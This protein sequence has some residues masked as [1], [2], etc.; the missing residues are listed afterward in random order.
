MNRRLNIA[1]LVI[2]LSFNTP[3]VAAESEIIEQLDQALK[4][5]AKFEYGKDSG[6]LVRVEQIVV[7]SAMDTK[8]RDAVERRLIRTLA[9]A[10]TRDAKSFLCRQ[11]RTI[12]TARCVPEL[13]KLLTDPELSHMARYALGRIDAPEAGVALHR[14]LKKTSG[15][16]KAGIIN[17]LVEVNYGRALGDFMGLIGNSDKDV[18]IAAIRATGHFPCNSSVS[19][20]RR[21]RRSA[22][23]D[24]QIEISAALL[25]SAEVFLANGD[26]KRS[27]AIY[28][29]FYSGNYP[30]HLRV[31]GL[32]GLAISQGAQAAPLLIEA[33][34]GDDS[35]LRRSS[36]EFMTMVKGKEAT[37]AFVALLPSLQPDAQVLV[38]GALGDRGDAAAAQAIS[39]ATRSEH[40]AVRVAA[41]EA[42]GSVGNASAVPLLARTAATAGDR[43]KKV[44]LAGLVLLSGDD[45][46][47]VLIRS[48]NSG[49]SKVRTEIIRAIAARGVTQATGEL[50]K[51]ATD[52]NETVRREAIRALGAL[53]DVSELGV[54][55]ALAVNPKDAKD[56]AA[57]EQTIG[58]VFRRVKDK[59]SQAGPLLAALAGAPPD[60]RPMLLRLLG[61]PA[62]PKA[63]EAVRAA[64]KDRSAEVRDAAVRTLSEWPNAAPA[65][66]LLALARTSTNRTH[67][68]LALRGY[69]RMA[70]MSKDPTTMYIRA[71]ELAER[72]DDKKL[73]LGGLGSANSAQALALVERYLKDKKLQAE[74]ALAAVQIAK[75]LQQNDATR[76]RV[77]L[78]NV[79]AV[80]K[81]PRIRQQAQDIINEME[82][83]EGY[84][85]VWLAA[86]P[87][88]EK[89]KEGRAIFDMVFPPEKPDAKDVKWKRLTQGIGSW[90]INLEA[91]FG[92]RNH[93]GAYMRTQIWSPAGQG[94]RLELGS[95]DAIKVWLN[96]KLV[97][98][99]YANRG[100]SPR[101]DLVDVKL[102]NGWNELVLKVVDNEGGWGFCCRVRKSDG[103]ALE[104]VKVEAK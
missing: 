1:L 63:L 68:V 91:T 62:T 81:D 31:A 94:A 7:E 53:V 46:D 11:L 74:A 21:A 90:D 86:G 82:Q 69:V 41:L 29:D 54:L 34:K 28:E 17:T 95:D 58:T 65:G 71:M 27:A 42:L 51:A 35:D 72:P 67:K 14:A 37:G 15:K 96:G 30:G 97:H 70:G 85:L 4:D 26:K 103:S 16:I 50:L 48:V 84:V 3:V 49:D 92:G 44:A 98:A 5:V 6:P 33:I 52:D 61:R 22:D 40:E 77:A 89:G 64:L 73:V 43:E 75:R 39:A 56:R 76:A 20:L 88:I 66:Q 93:C 24:I 13:E 104:G 87:Y 2:M 9:S 32:R 8:L 10:S 47:A 79:V 102:R 55:V 19:A 12:G 18:A 78:K 38:L 45:V 99:N 100:M 23:K 80:V 57:I 101:Q 25:T 59:D 83:Y 60:A 36:I